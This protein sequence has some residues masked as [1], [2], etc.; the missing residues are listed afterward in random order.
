MTGLPYIGRP[1]DPVYPLI[2]FRRFIGNVNTILRLNRIFNEFDY[3]SIR[4]KT[5]YEQKTRV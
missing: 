1:L 3:L 2:S 5:K 4:F